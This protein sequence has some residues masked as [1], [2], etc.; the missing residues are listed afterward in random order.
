MRS[1]HDEQMKVFILN[2]AA[3]LQIRRG[4]R[5]NLGIIFHIALLKYM[6]GPVIRTVSSR[7][8]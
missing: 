2:S 7:E 5:N 4:K 8:L 1:D 3:V 6:L